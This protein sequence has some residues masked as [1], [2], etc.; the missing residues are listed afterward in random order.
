MSNVINTQNSSGMGERTIVPEEIAK[1]F[2][3][4]AFLGTWIWGLGNKTYITLLVF[5]AGLI[6]FVGFIAN[7]ALAIWFGVKGNEWAWRNKRFD[8]IN[9]F[10]QYQRMWAVI[11]IA[12]SVLYFI[13]I[14]FTLIFFVSYF[15]NQPQIKV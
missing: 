9:H 6:P 2:N 11:S 12:I 10:N 14:A 3:W 1:E 15:M 7:F 13:I 8:S 5:V 4:G